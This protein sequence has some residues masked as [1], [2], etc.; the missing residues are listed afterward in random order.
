MRLMLPIRD[1]APVNMEGNR[2]NIGACALKKGGTG[3]ASALLPREVA[4]QEDFGQFA[5]SEILK[6]Q[7]FL[8]PRNQ[9]GFPETIGGALRNANQQVRSEPANPR[10][11][12]TIFNTSTIPPDQMRPA[13][14]IGQGAE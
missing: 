9:I 2:I 6:G 11:P 13:F 8:D 12:V 1:Y 7:N 4:T 10:N 14:E 5:P 3:L